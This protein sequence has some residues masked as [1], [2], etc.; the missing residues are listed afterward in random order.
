MV[1]VASA[2]ECL[3]HQMRNPRPEM[4]HFLLRTALSF[5]RAFEG[6][7]AGP[8]SGGWWNVRASH[9]AEEPRARV[10][11]VAVGGGL[12][13][14]EHFGGFFARQ[15]HEVAQLHQPRF[16]LVLRGQLFQRL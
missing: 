12:G 9:L 6:W 16:A 5:R 2:A 4:N 1:A 10:G 3:R 8:L 11:P 7:F 15:A 13:D 14:A